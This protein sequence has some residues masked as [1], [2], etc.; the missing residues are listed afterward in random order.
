MFIQK[1]AESVF[2]VTLVYLG[3][4]RPPTMKDIRPSPAVITVRGAASILEEVDHVVAYIGTDR[5]LNQEMTFPVQAL[6]AQGR[7]LAGLE[8]DPPEIRVI[9]VADKGEE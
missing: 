8:I 9:E 1:V 3:T 4:D 5:A 6:D 7:S 2:P